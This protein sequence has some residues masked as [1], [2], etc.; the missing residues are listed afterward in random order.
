[1]SVAFSDW[2]RRDQDGGR[3]SFDRQDEWKR[4]IPR[5][6]ADRPV[7]PGRYFGHRNGDCWHLEAKSKMQVLVA[8]SRNRKEPP[9]LF[10]AIYYI[11]NR[12]GCPTHSR[13]LRMS[14]RWHHPA[15]KEQLPTA[16]R[17]AGLLRWNRRPRRGR[18][19]QQSFGA[20]ILVDV[21]PMNSVTAAGNFPVVA[22]RGC[23]VEQPRIPDKR[24]GD[25]ASVAQ[26][27]A[28]GVLGEL[29]VQ[30]ALVRT[31]MRRR[32]RK[33]HSMPPETAA[34]NLSPSI[35]SRAV[36]GREIQSCPPVGRD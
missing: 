8:L 1:M 13:T 4:F 17:S 11:P 2:A 20:Q 12:A 7:D 18:A 24:H 31:A 6:E 15:L 23:G 9:G 16:K 26:A 28:D 14:G 33:T 5:V 22:L 21:G 29:D 19:S 10:I 25:D 34:A 27:H 30:H 32:C 35:V 3:R 36:R